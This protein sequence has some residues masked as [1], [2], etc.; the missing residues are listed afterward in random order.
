MSR[1]IRHEH[2][3]GLAIGPMVVHHGMRLRLMIQERKTG[4]VLVSH[5][6]RPRFA[7]AVSI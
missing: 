2:A 5:T 6:I 1:G 7:R 3:V 4:A